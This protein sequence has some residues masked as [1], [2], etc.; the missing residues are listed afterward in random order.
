[1][2]HILKIDQDLSLDE[3]QKI[4]DNG[5]EFVVYQYCIS[6][7]F[8]VT[9]I[10]F[11]P[12]FLITSDNKEINYKKKYNLISWLLGWWAIPYGPTY[13]ISSF[14]INRKG[15]MRVT[16]DIMLNITPEYLKNR[17]VILEKTNELFCKPCKD[18]RKAIEKCV[19][20]DLERDKNI[21]QLVVGL[22]INTEEY[23]DPILTIG[24]R[25][26]SDF[27]AYI[28]IVKKALY[29]QFRRSTDFDFVDLNEENEAY[30]LLEK[31]G[32]SFVDRRILS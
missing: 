29:R 23:E 22:F 21:E 18:D 3:L 11:S 12:A 25:V 16:E 28:E 9:L 13:T 32:E 2:T 7:F 30:R 24:L 4:I 19:N 5:G 26:N 17:E 31:Q 14:S 15:G 20:R 10:R 27:E 6:V 1:M 8:A